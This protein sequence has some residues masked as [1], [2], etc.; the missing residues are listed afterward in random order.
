MKFQ[1]RGSRS[2]KP[3]FSSNVF[4]FVTPATSVTI[5]GGKRKKRRLLSDDST[6]I[7]KFNRC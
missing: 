1:K 4:R 3:Y 6:S 2:C 5:I 7:G